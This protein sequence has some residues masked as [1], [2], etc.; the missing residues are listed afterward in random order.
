MNQHDLF[1]VGRS[2]I[3]AMFIMSAIGKAANWK[4]TVDLMQDRKSVV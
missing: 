3:A 4:P 1:L 2:L